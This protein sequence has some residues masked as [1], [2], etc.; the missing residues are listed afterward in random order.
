M[1]LKAALSGLC[2]VLLLII[3]L[4]TSATGSRAQSETPTPAAPLPEDWLAQ[5]DY[6]QEAPLTIT[7]ASVEDMDGIA[8][9]DISFPS[10]VDGKDIAAYLVVPPGDG[11]F[12]AILFVHWLGPANSNRDEFRDEAIKLA[13]SGVVSLLVNTVWSSPNP[14]PWKAEDETGDVAVTTQA[15]IELRRAIDILVSQP[16]VDPERMAYV[17]HDFGAMVGGTLAGVDD[18]LKG[19]VLMAGAPRYWPWTIRWTSLHDVTWDAYVEK[20]APWT[21]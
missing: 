11:P 5:F 10:P 2:L 16:N 8:V 19:Y 12:P 9:H 1:K 20:C 18:R 15:V 21:R 7:E 17:G 14:L 3:G 6:D 13:K 4:G